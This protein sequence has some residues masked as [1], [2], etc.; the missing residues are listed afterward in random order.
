MVIYLCKYKVV[1][2]A[3]QLVCLMNIWNL[4]HAVLREADS[5]HTRKDKQVPRWEN[6]CQGYNISNKRTIPAEP[7]EDSCFPFEP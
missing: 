7:S 5:L 4:R 1:G 6:L 3:P 2:A